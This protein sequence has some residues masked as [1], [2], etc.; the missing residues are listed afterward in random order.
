[1]QKIQLSALHVI[2]VHCPHTIQEISPRK[3]TTPVLHTIW[4]VDLFQLE[5]WNWQNE[6]ENVLTNWKRKVLFYFENN[7][8]WKMQRK[9]RQIQTDRC[10]G[11]KRLCER[12]S[13]GFL[14]NC[15]GCQ[16]LLLK[17]ITED[18]GFGPVWNSCFVVVRQAK[19]KFLHQSGMQMYWTTIYGEWGN[20]FLRSIPATWK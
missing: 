11:Q 8:G 10:W 18:P 14:W 1:M 2:P 5:T 19:V 6:D 16:A 20:G 15:K 7:N 13:S 3:K 4:N 17:Q 9:L 12:I